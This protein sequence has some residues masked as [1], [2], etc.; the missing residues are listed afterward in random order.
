[1]KLTKEQISKTFELMQDRS[2]APQSDPGAA[3][4]YRPS[5]LRENR[6]RGVGDRRSQA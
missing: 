4:C 6:P 2:D 5:D 3:Q 1:M